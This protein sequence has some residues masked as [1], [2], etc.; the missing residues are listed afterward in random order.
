MEKINF[1]MEEI[2]R[3]IKNYEGLYQVSNTGKIKS[4]ERYK[5][6]GSRLQLVPEIELKQHVNFYRNGYCS[7][8]LSKNGKSKRI[9]VH[10]LVAKA[11]PE[12]CGEWFTSVII[13]SVAFFVLIIPLPII[14]STIV[15]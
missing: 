11:F 8:N 1:N 15:L 9:K 12:I 6:N 5:K 7:V 4:L 2:W 10:Q 14:A 13:R 3:D